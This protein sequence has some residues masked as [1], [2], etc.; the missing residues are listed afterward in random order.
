[1]SKIRKGDMVRI[2]AGKDFTRAGTDGRVLAMDKKNNR[3]VVEGVGIVQ[4]HKKANARQSQQGGII[5]TESAIHLSNVMYLHK[6]KP[7]RIG[8]DVE[9]KREGDK[10][11]K[12]IKRIA[13]TTGD[14]IDTQTIVKTRAPKTS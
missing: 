14:V 1:M 11:T 5:K 3:V 9:I 7:T 4:K 12:T 8:I 13:K 2:I 10:T 6:G